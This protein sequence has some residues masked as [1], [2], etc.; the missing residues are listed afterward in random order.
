MMKYHSN[1]MTNSQKLYNEAK[2]QNL[3]RVKGNYIKFKG[4]GAHS[5][6]FLNDKVIQGTNFNT[7]K[8]EQKIKY[9]FEENGEQKVY[10]TAVMTKGDDGQ[11][12]LSNFVEQMRHYN[13]GDK[14]IIEYKRIPGTPRGFIE[15]RPNNDEQIP[16]INQVDDSQPE[17][18]DES[19]PSPEDLE[20]PEQEPEGDI[21][22]SL[23]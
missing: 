19:E 13:Y 11:A 14:I 23:Y 9:L 21:P 10:N 12:R 2:E 16:I 8:P 4:T 3:V 15:V 7:G 5:L 18:V 22:P 17:S 6:I 20:S 1:Y